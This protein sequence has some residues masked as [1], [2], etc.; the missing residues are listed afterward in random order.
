MPA[1]VID[2][3]PGGGERYYPVRVHK[4]REP[5]K[6]GSVQR[7]NTGEIAKS[8][9]LAPQGAGDEAPFVD[10]NYLVGPTR[11]N[12]ASMKRFVAV[13]QPCRSRAP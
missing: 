2:E 7:H 13:A 9:A 4:G 11:P 6:Q 1:M 3:R 5:N 12:F 8:T 10:G